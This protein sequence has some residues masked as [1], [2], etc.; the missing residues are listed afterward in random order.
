[1]KTCKYCC[2]EI[3][4]RARVCPVC[5]RNI[6]LTG[7]VSAFFVT[8][9]PVLTALASLGF[10]FYEKYERLYVQDTLARTETRLEVVEVQKEVA[11]DA[12]S[13]LNQLAPPALMSS[14]PREFTRETGPPLSP[15]QQLQEIDAQIN[16]ATQGKVIDTQRLREL[17][18]RR[19]ELQNNRN[20]F[21]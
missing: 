10:A 19:L 6:T 13:R 12:V 4:R 7:S 16:A 3:N 8:V 1:M 11:Q 17:E 14:A 18:K 2:E 21:F 20:I 9:L 15:D 5:H